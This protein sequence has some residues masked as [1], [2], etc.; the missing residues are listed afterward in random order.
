MRSPQSHPLLR[1]TSH[2]PKKTRS[3]LVYTISL[4]LATKKGTRVKPQLFS[5]LFICNSLISC[6]TLTF[7]SP[8]FSHHPPET[9]SLLNSLLPHPLYPPS[10]VD[11][12][13]YWHKGRGMKGPTTSVG[14]GSSRVELHKSSLYETPA[15]YLQTTQ[16]TISISI[17]TSKHKISFIPRMWTRGEQ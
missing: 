16:Q 11:L 7:L 14:N 9:L 5:D 12:V 2:L 6:A 1:D 3:S 4:S 15:C 10:L 13:T 8:S 17:I